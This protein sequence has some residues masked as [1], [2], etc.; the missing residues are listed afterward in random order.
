MTDDPED[1]LRYSDMLDEC[2]A[3]ESLLDDCQRRFIDTSRYLLE[4]DRPFGK[5][6]RQSV[7]AIWTRLTEGN[8]L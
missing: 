7:R 8:S 5:T 3:N 2:E 6:R 4:H 1:L